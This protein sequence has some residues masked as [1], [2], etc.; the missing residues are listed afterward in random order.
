MFRQE[1]KRPRI[2]QDK[3][4][5]R[6]KDIFHGIRYRSPADYS[7]INVKRITDDSRKVKDGDLFIAVR[8]YNTDGYKFIASAVKR[9]AGIIV[10]DKAFNAPENIKKIIVKD[11]RSCLPV[12]ADNFYGHPSEKLKVI[13][14]T[15]TNG[16]TT[17]TYLMENILNTAKKKNGVIG[18]INYRVAG[19]EVPSTNT[20][21]GVLE[22]ESL[23][24]EMLKKNA[25][26]VVMEVSSHSLDQD[27][28][29]CVSFDAGIFTNITKEHLDYHKT[30]KN[31]FGA[32]ARLFE[33]LKD[34][35]VAVLNNDD[36]MAASLKR[37][38]RKKVLT[39]GI[40]K[41]ADIKALD[42]R[43][44]M[45]ASEFVIKTL[46]GSFNARTNLIGRHNISNI[47]AS[48]TASI[49]LGIGLDVIRKGIGSFKTVPGRLESV[50]MGQPFK[51]FVD[52]AHTE[53]A[54]YNVLSL[55]RDVVARKSRIITVFGCGGN[56]DRTKRPLMGSIAC[57]FSDRVV[58]TSDNPRFEDPMF[59]ISEIEKGVKNK[60]T[61]YD[62]MPDR[63]DAIDK[64]LRLA[65]EGDVVVLAGKGHE[66]C[67][68][69]GDEA[70]PFDD[71]EIVKELLATHVS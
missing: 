9:G 37:R 23:L 19:K 16:K 17:I 22:I 39:Y 25:E 6:I 57:R 53:D 18:T 33:K 65:G 52:Y 60:F 45:D 24:S 5:P 7:G 41:D 70:I 63:R 48:T 12:M 64:A 2:R 50:D 35:G 1:K 3:F 20:T 8:G 29:G 36:A 40:E 46:E 55:L 71:R 47:L 68:I 32:K 54:L 28:V 62:I 44:S 27:R 61:N 58:V 59:I 26:Y 66:K 30:M 4:M 69:I 14:V 49:A 21:P 51:I 42:I 43:L 56:R 13:G 67:Q 31:Y 34:K 38:I 10:A 11:A 15:G